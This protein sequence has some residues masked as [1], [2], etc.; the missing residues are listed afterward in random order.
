MKLCCR[1]ILSTRP[2]DYD[3]GK[4]YSVADIWSYRSKTYYRIYDNLNET[5]DFS[6]KDLNTYFIT[7]GEERKLKI[8]K[9][10]EK[11]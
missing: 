3:I 11:R 9:L 6:K 1:K 2:N 10:N 4:Y 5:H 7:L 8:Q